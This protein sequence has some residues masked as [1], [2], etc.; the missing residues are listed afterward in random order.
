MSWTTVAQIFLCL[1]ILILFV[2][3]AIACRKI[4][5]SRHDISDP[6]EQ[7]PLVSQGNPLVHIPMEKN[8]YIT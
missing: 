6:S 4:Y 3:V 1:G 2:C 5:T 8:T 7:E